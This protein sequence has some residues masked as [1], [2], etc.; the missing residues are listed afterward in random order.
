M[1]YFG[2]N[3]NMRAISSLVEEAEGIRH[4]WLNR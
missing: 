1:N 2:V 4:K 3:G